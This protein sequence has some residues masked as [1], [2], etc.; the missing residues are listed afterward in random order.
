MSRCPAGKTTP[1]TV[2]RPLGTGRCFCSETRDAQGTLPV[3][4]SCFYFCLC[5]SQSP[6]LR[7]PVGD[8]ITNHVQWKKR[9]YLNSGV[10]N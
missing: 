2:P 3:A 8:Q 7:D 4:P 10:K 1:P 6:A 5:V 9:L